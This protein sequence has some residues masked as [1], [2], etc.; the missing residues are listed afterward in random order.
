MQALDELHRQDAR[1]RP[2][3]VD[4]GHDHALVAGEELADA[5]G[6]ARL[7][8]EVELASRVLRELGDRRRGPEGDRLRPAAL[9]PAGEERQQREVALDLLGDAG[10]L[11]LHRHDAT[12]GQRRSVHL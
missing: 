12:V 3:G 1:R 5:L 2:L 11:H 7:A 6:G 4:R 8:P 10:T 9:D